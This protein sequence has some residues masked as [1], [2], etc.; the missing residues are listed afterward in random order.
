MPLES[1]RDISDQSTLSETPIRAIVSLLHD[2]TVPLW[3][4]HSFF[5]PSLLGSKHWA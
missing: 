3:L 4:I 1:Q 2:F 5:M